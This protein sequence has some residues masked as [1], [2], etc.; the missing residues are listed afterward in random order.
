M[1]KGEAALNV[2]MDSKEQIKDLGLPEL[3]LWDGQK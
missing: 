3:P 1:G 2:G